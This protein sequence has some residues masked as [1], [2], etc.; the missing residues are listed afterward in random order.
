MTP[1]RKL[2]TFALVSAPLF[3]A[4]QPKEDA[5]TPGPT[6]G[7]ASA[8]EYRN[9]TPRAEAV[10]MVVPGSNGDGKGLTVE[11]HSQGLT[12]MAGQTAE[13]YQVT[14]IGST[15]FNGAAVLVLGL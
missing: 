8:D 5:A 14:R 4:C 6:G 10:A 13:F 15:V 11:S 2:L 12:A 7:Q 1:L 9:A 3:G